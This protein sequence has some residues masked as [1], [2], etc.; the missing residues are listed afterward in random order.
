M[1]GNDV[2]WVSFSV[3]RALLR[4]SFI[5][6]IYI[7]CRIILLFICQY[8]SIY[9][10]FLCRSRVRGRRV[11]ACVLACVRACVRVCMCVCFTQSVLHWCCN[12]N[13]SLNGVFVH[14][15]LICVGLLVPAPGTKP[16]AYTRHKQTR[17][18]KQTKATCGIKASGSLFCSY[19]CTRARTHTHTH[20][21]TRTRTHT[22]TSTTTKNNNSNNTWCHCI[23]RQE[24]ELILSLPKLRIPVFVVETAAANEH[25]ETATAADEH[26]ENCSWRT[27]RKLQLTNTLTNTEETAADEHWETAADEHWETAAA[28]VNLPPPGCKTA[29]FHW[30]H[31]HGNSR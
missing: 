23:K 18:E 4:S 7:H 25:R 12:W 6:I 8:F 15:T 27:L 14:I 26:W 13:S 11:R 3:L 16:G 9:C 20:T 31:T 10:L 28:N 24:L 21:R 17:L 1:E 29:R 30:L 22:T 2:F 19:T 5:F